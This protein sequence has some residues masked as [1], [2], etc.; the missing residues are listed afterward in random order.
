M[1]ESEAIATTVGVGFALLG[2]ACMVLVVAGIPGTWILI[3]AAILVDFL[4]WLW[5]PPGSPLTFH[6]ITL[7]I[8]VV[9]ALV[10]EGLELLLSAFGARRFG[11]SWR[12]M[13]G[14]VVGGVLGAIFGTFTIPILVVG[15]LAGA[16]VGT[17]LGAVVG[18]LWTGERTLR[19]ST[20]PALGAVIGRVLGM[21]VKL[22]IALVVWVVLAIAAFR[23]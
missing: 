23:A 22:P 4:D 21:L 10:G 13:L 16:A 19:D 5:L 20:Q 8:A 12:G 11:A 1:T 18:E 6:P 14:S 3:G 15:T 17:A 9:V 7:A 2:A